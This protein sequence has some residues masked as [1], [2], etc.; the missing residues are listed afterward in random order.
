MHKYSDLRPEQLAASEFVYRGDQSLLLADVGTGKTVIVLSALK[1]W[2]DEGICD[3]ALIVAP[4]RVCTDVWEQ[5]TEEWEHLEALKPPFIVSIAGESVRVRKTL[6]DN[7]LTHRIVLVNYENLPWLMETYPKGVKGFNVLVMDE[8]D[9]LKDP[10]TLRFKGRPRRK[11]PLTKN[12]VPAISGMKTWRENFDIHIG[13]TGTPTPNHLLDLWAQVYMVDGGQ[14]L[15]SNYYRFRDRHFF[16]TDWMGYAY[17]ILPGREQWIQERIA[18]ITFRLEQSKNMPGVVETPIRWVDMSSRTRSVYKELAREYIVYLERAVSGE[19]DRVEADNA[20]VVYGKL[21]QL[22]AGFLYVGADRETEWLSKVKFKELD[23]LISELQGQQLL[24]VY[25]YHAQLA[26]LKRRY[27]GLRHLGGGQSTAVATDTI[28]EWNAGRLPFLAL[29]PASAGHGLNLQKSH[30]AHIAMLTEPE[31]AGLYTQVI[32]RLARTGGASTV[33]VHRIL[34]RD[35][36]DIE[37][38]AAVHNKT[39]SQTEL[40]NDMKARQL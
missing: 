40:L 7:A 5:E 9:K 31:S 26:E 20:A 23:N 30:A 28:T 38:D 24:I 11:D 27:K 18:D 29:H 12:V 35:S 4:K 8:I 19:V 33:F 1:R 39:L 10:T 15:G 6:L 22:C 37:Q 25:H 13:M 14:R 16:Q 36:Q 17:D 32:G 34:L 21:R 2:I 3:R